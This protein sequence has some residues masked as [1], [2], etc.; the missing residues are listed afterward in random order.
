MKVKIISFA[1]AAVLFCILF[2]SCEKNNNSSPYPVISYNN[3]IQYCT[4]SISKDSVTV[5]EDSAVLIINFSDGNGDI[6]YPSSDENAPFDFY[7]QQYY[8][9]RNDSIIPI[10]TTDGGDVI[11]PYHI[12]DI[13][14]SGADKSLT[15]EI[16]ILLTYPNVDYLA[17]TKNP[18]ARGATICYKVWIY[19]RS[20]NKSNVVTTPLFT[21]CK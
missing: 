10:I 15:G 2:N 6:G 12:P 14:P 8:L 20:G 19:D 1:I 21:L 5:V 17:N 7:I 4:G 9:N 3:L 11:L 13:T 16:K 18:I